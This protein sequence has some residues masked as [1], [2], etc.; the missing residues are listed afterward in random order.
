MWMKWVV[1]SF[2][3]EYY[4]STFTK[5]PIKD[6][7]SCTYIILAHS[8]VSAVSLLAVALTVSIQSHVK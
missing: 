1:I 2:V 6:T 7:K 3:S 8:L 4:H 5:K